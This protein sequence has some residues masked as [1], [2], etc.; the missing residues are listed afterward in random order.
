MKTYPPRVLSTALMLSYAFINKSNALT[1]LCPAQR[2]PDLK[3]SGINPASWMR[4]LRSRH[5]DERRL[6]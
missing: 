6:K 1:C 2:H 5:H 4:K 3:G